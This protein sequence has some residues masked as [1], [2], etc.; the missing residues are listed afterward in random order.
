M[1]DLLVVVVTVLLLLGF[2]L[3]YIAKSRSKAA[4]VSCV[5]Q[6]KQVGLAFRMWSKDSGERF[7][8]A[9]STN[10]GGTKEYSASP[11]PLPHFRA[12]SNELSSAKVLVCPNDATRKRASAWSEFT[13]SM[14]LSYFIC[15][16]AEETQPQTVLSGDRTLSTNGVPATGFVR[17][18]ASEKLSWASGVHP[19][20]GN[21]V[22]GDG[23]GHQMSPS[24]L[25]K[26][27][28]AAFQSTTQTVHRLAIPQ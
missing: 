19:G 24:L 16:E 10:V 15:F 14:N 27:F 7:P 2:V 18:T 5:N 25:S 12:I 17:L 6:L 1:W 9:D 8:W 26:Q 3:P 13:T 11:D 28:Q 22:L 4:K 20:F 23:S 21:L